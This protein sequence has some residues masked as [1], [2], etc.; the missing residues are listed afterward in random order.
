MPMFHFFSLHQQIQI[1][2]IS[3]N[4][5][6]TICMN[7]VIECFFVFLFFC[8]FWSSGQV[9]TSVMKPPVGMAVPAMTMGMPFAAPAHLAGG[10]TLA[11][12]VRFYVAYIKFS[13]R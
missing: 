9:R 11:I 10:E 2:L 5:S 6:Y 1:S 12:Q 3:L 7:C 4:K 8:F 13:G